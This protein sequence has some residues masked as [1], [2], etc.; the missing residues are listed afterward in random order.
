MP[1]SWFTQARAQEPPPAPTA[2]PSAQPPP[3]QT[4]PEQGGWFQQARAQLPPP[5]EQSPSDYLKQAAIN[6]PGSAVRHVTKGV[7]GPLLSP[8]DT[9]KGFYGISTGLVQKFI[10]GEQDNEEYVA[11]AA[12]LLKQNFGTPERFASTFQARPGG[13]GDDAPG[14][15]HLR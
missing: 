14:Q 6:V 10:P 15:A 12:D 9:A 11:A 4:P 3:E 5:S 13:H 8:I 7:V 2:V 1:Q